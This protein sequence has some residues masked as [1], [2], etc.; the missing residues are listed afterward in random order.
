MPHVKN[1]LGEY[2]ELI[3]SAIRT[4]DSNP[5]LKFGGYQK[6]VKFRSPGRDVRI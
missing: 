3:P 4:S 5:N 2:P 6:V 1:E